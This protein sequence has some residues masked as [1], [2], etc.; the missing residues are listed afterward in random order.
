V[1]FLY[2]LLPLGYRVNAVISG[3]YK[4]LHKGETG[5]HLEPFSDK[6]FLFLCVVERG[7]MLIKCE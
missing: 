6:G 7:T 3:M 4:K 1:H 5:S 2:I